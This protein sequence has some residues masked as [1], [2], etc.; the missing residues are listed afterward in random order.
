MLLTG[1]EIIARAAYD[2]GCRLMFGYPITPSSEIITYFQKLKGAEFVQTEDEIAAGFSVCGAILAGKITFTASAGIGHVLMQDAMSMAEA[3]RLPFV[4]IVMQRGG[5]STGQVSYSQQETILATHG[6]N[7][8]GLRI[9]YSP[10]TARELY[11]Y[12]Y[13]TFNAAWKYKFPAILLADGYL[14]KA[15]TSLNA[16]TKNVRQVVAKPIL[17]TDKIKNL[18]NCYGTEEEM[19]AVLLKNI[20][21][22]EKVRQEIEE[23]ETLN[24]ANA[25]LVVVV[26]GIVGAAAKSALEIL[27]DKKIG[28]FRPI[29]LRPFPAS[30]FRRLVPDKAKIMVIESANGQLA[31]ILASEVNGTKIDY[32]FYKPGLGITPEE[33]INKLRMTNDE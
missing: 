10:A 33:I 28:L 11:Y 30:A 23:Y 31:Q 17:E 25:K 26:A 15:K 29:T 3:M 12:T 16:L 27:G 4:L 1:N 19:A 5:P 13:K 9:V 6:G 24:L 20:A 2:S 32:H 14:A 7:G 18:R 8:E 22:Y 21:E